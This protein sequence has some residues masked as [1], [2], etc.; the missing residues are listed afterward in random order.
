MVQ[1]MSADRSL[2]S[3]VPQG[4][5]KTGSWAPPMVVN[6]ADKFLRRL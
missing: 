4:W 3:V 6:I 5:V 1:A 2:S